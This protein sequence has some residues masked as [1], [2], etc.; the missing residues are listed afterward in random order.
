MVEVV[1]RKNLHI[2]YISGLKNGR[3]HRTKRGKKWFPRFALLSKVAFKFVIGKCSTLQKNLDFWTEK[4]MFILQADLFFEDRSTAEFCK[5]GKCWVCCFFFFT[6][7]FDRFW[8]FIWCEISHGPINAFYPPAYAVENP[9]SL[10]LEGRSRIS[11]P[12]PTR[13]S[14]PGQVSSLAPS[15]F[16]GSLCCARPCI[17]LLCECRWGLE[18][19]WL[20]VKANVGFHCLDLTPLKMQWFLF[21]SPCPRPPQDSDMKK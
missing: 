2:N 18:C 7:F 14:T 1:F 15:F 20:A 13:I 4:W 17:S 21:S 6:I 16:C 3:T 10:S 19:C 9:S 12:A 8:L 11:G 5:H